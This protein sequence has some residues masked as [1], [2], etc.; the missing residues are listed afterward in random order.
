MMAARRIFLSVSAKSSHW[1]QVCESAEE[2]VRIAMELIEHEDS[3]IPQ[4]RD[5]KLL[6]EERWDSRTHIVFD[7]LHDSYKSEEAHLPGHGDLPV[8]AV[9]LSKKQVV[10]TASE[11]IRNKVNNE[12]Q[13]IHRLFGEGSQP[14]FFIDHSGGKVPVFMNPRT[15]KK[16]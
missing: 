14:P 8:I 4:W 15:I 16:Q 10:Q 13:E 1:P 2:A 3:I 6:A 5:P 12:V 9:W 7:I 11:G